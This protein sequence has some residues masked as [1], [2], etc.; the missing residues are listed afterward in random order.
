MKKE[1]ILKLKSIVE[2]ALY[3]INIAKCTRSDKAIAEAKEEAQ[4]I[5]YP[6]KDRLAEICSMQY[7]NGEL[8]DWGHL[9]NDLHDVYQE[10]CNKEDL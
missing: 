2:K 5:V 9:E 3:K 1:E 8:F 4:N 6:H 7:F 10:L